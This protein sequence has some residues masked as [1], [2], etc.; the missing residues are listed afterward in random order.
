MG[1]ASPNFS[2]P[3]RSSESMLEPRL[4]VNAHRMRAWT[5]TRFPRERLRRRATAV[6][7]Q[8]TIEPN[9]PV[10]HKALKV[11]PDWVE[12]ALAGAKVNGVMNR[13]PADVAQARELQPIL[14]FG[15]IKIRDWP[16]SE[17]RIVS[18]G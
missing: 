12:G 13:L 17:V 8:P 16:R 9:V 2:L 3:W 15:D 11:I 10:P 14:R 1:G 4:D 7:C 6:G 18:V 5:L